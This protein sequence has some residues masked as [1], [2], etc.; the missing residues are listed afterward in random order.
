MRISLV[1]LFSILLTSCERYTTDQFTVINVDFQDVDWYAERAQLAY[2][3]KDDI[4]K[5]LDTVLHVE[6]I[7]ERDIQF[8]IEQLPGNRQLISVRGTANLANVR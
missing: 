6:S 2:S 8:F 3:S 5:G 7:P 1:L 4:T